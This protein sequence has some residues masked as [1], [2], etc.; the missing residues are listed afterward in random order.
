MVFADGRHP[1]DKIKGKIFDLGLTMVYD[2]LSS[3]NQLRAGDKGTVRL[4]GT[5]I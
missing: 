5:I 2:L 3:A 1:V 4:I